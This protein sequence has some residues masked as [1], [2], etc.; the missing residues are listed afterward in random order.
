MAT[1]Y[2][3]VKVTKE[4]KRFDIPAQAD[5]EDL[6]AHAIGEVLKQEKT[7]LYC[8]KKSVE[9]G[10]MGLRVVKGDDTWTRHYIMAAHCGALERGDKVAREVKKY[11]LSPSI[12]RAEERVYICM[13]CKKPVHHVLRCPRC[14]MAFY[15]NATCQEANWTAHK[16]HCQHRE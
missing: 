7:C 10:L 13:H 15:C 8:Q 2:Y 16:S 1:I 6:K 5:E 11:S 4:W 9:V 12:A 14:K 3:I